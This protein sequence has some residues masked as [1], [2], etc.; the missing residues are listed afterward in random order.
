M[1]TTVSGAVSKGR[2]ARNVFNG[3]EANQGPYKLTGS[4]NEAYIIVTKF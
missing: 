3:V 2:Y 1:R 4:E